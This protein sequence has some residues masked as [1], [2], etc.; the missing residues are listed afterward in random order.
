MIYH[1]LKDPFQVEYSE[2]GTLSEEDIYYL[3]AGET[4]ES[5][6][7][8][9]IV[10]ATILKFDAERLTLSCKLENGLDAF[11]SSKEINNESIATK[12]EMNKIKPGS[13]I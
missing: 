5:L 2:D 3:C 12:E 11:L 1:E 4:R 9:S 13:V 8:G 10:S 7:K 6:R